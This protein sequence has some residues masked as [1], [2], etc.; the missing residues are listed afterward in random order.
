MEKVAQT[1][2]NQRAWVIVS[3]DKCP[4]VR[5]LS[6]LIRSCDKRGFFTFVGRENVDENSRTLM[7]ELAATS[8]SLLLID[9]HGERRQGPEAIPFIMKNLPSG[10]LA[11]VLYL[12]PGTMWLTHQL[13]MYVSRNRNKI[14][15]LTV[16]AP[17]SE[18]GQNA[19]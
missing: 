9:D 7:K 8:W 3:D 10:R 14:A 11:C 19:A 12:I 4:V 1:A 18:Q 6:R 16:P 15:T 2:D 13:Y 5:S 17:K